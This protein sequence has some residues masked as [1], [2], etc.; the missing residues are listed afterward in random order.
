[1]KSICLPICL[2][3]LLVSQLAEA[4]RPIK[5]ESM[6]K[7]LR[8]MEDGPWEFSPDAY[9]Y[10]WVRRHRR[11]GFFEWS[12]DEP[13]LGVHDKG[14]AGIGLGDGYVNKYKPSG[15]VRAQMLALAEVTRKQYEAIAEKHKQI[16]EREALDATDRSID[17]AIKVYQDRINTS[18]ATIYNQ[19]MALDKLKY[20]NASQNYLDELMRIK[21]NIES[22]GKSYSRNAER[23]RA[24]LKE[25]TNLGRLSQSLDRACR[26]AYV[27]TRTTKL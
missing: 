13:G 11:I 23:S 18:Y 6:Y 7:Q 25:I 26:Q 14:P 20:P 24:Y 3:L 22:I 21:A 10:S 8:S 9:Y 1:M 19:C 12:W 15:R 17:I 27:K 5:S 4:Q 16:G 2:F